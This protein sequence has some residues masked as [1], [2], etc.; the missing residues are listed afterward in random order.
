MSKQPKVLAFPRDPNPYQE[1]LYSPMREQGVV[2][3]YLEGPTGSQTVNLLL[4]PLMLIYRRLQGYSVLHVHWTWPFYLPWAKEAGR[5]PVQLLAGLCWRITKLLGYRLIW[6]AHNALPQDKHFFND[7]RAH[8]VLGNLAN[9]VITHNGAAEE[10][11]KAIGVRTNKK[12][13]KIIP[14]GSYVGAYPDTVSRKDARRKLNIPEDDIVLLLFGLIRP[15]KGVEQFLAA[16]DF[17]PDADKKHL[18]VVVAGPP[19]DEGLVRQLRSARQKSSKKIRLDLK[20]IS[21][22]DVQFYFRS[23]DFTVLPYQASTTSGVALLAM[24]FG[25]PVIVPKQPA[26]AGLPTD[27]QVSYE[28]DG[29]LAALHNA[30]RI[31]KGRQKNMSA[32]AS[33]YATALSWP[34]IAKRTM[35]YF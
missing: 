13:I 12:H 23:A 6:T 21:E 14:H 18:T 22:K 7:K 16:Y 3:D 34:Q 29:L 33:E 24:S 26:F 10:Q 2:I 17:L 8:R 32:A 31:P 15:Y 20:F 11:L 25:C 5:L 28:I 27:A 9:V 1:L 30:I 35:Y 4:L 19:R